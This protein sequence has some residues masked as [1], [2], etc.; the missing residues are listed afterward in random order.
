M[1]YNE[2]VYGA[3][4]DPNGGFY[5]GALPAP[6]PPQP[7]G[8]PAWKGFLQNMGPQQQ[9]GQRKGMLGG[10]QQMGNMGLGGA[11]D[12]IAGAAKFFL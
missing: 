8:Q 12:A 7:Q 2:N 4:G 11:G 3:D 9:P 1:S 6:Q 5:G 10:M